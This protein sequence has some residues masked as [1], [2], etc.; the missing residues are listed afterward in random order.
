MLD[1]T[2]GSDL[3]RVIVSDVVSKTWS[4]LSLR[5]SI[6]KLL[7]FSYFKAFFLSGIEASSQP[8]GSVK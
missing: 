5:K 8:V 3:D 2:L 1:P 7:I 4:I 6:A